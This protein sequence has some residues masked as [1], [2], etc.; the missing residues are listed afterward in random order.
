ML[1]AVGDAPPPGFNAFGYRIIKDD[2][3][4][5]PQSSD[6]RLPNRDERWT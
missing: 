4:T 5:N 1:E 6:R 2:R 3:K